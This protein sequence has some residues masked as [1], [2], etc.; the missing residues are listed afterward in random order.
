MKNRNYW[1]WLEEQPDHIRKSIIERSPWYNLPKDTPVWLNRLT[2]KRCHVEIDG[3]IYKSELTAESEKYLWGYSS[4][5]ND[6][7]YYS[8]G[9]IKDQ[10][11]YYYSKTKFAVEIEIFRHTFENCHKSIS[12]Q[13]FGC[14]D[15]DFKPADDSFL[16][17]R[18]WTICGQENIHKSH[19]QVIHIHP[20]WVCD[21]K[22]L[23]ISF[24]GGNVDY[25]YRPTDCFLSLEPLTAKQI[26]NI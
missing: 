25:R 16:A 13:L 10:F 5:V 6:E 15:P 7:H 2:T 22:H 21:Y 20:V 3:H 1:H 14:E 18:P 11:E 19:P 8:T 12:I 17:P 23:P 24:V 4:W 26:M 9:S